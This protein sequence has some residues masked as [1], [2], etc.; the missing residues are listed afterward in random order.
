MEWDPLEVKEEI[1]DLDEPGFFE[2]EDPDTGEITKEYE[3][4]ISKKEELETTTDFKTDRNL[5]FFEMQS[6]GILRKIRHLMLL[7]SSY[8]WLF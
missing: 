6:V 3:N 7:G 8:F 4:V 2:I 5:G 1:L